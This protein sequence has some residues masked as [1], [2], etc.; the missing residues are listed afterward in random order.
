MSVLVCFHAHP[1][2][3]VFGTGG[4]MRLAA[5]AGHRVVLVVATDGA[6]GQVPDGLLRPG[7]SLARRRRDEVERSAA[8]LG[9]D[10]VVHLGYGDSGMAGEPTPAATNPF[11]LAALGEASSRLAAVLEE[12]RPDV[13]TVYDPNGGYG[14]PDHI[15]VHNVGVRAAQQVGMD[16]V[17][18]SSINRDHMRAIMEM[19]AQ[20]NPDLADME[21]P[22]LDSIGLPA[23]A[24]TTTVDVTAAMAAKRAAMLIH[25]TQI[26]DFGPMLGMDQ[27]QL[28]A[29]FGTEWFRRHGAEP[30]LTES[31]LPL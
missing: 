18:E 6:A 8:T 29:A 5:D 4:V 15:M 24:F 20:H 9:A 23:D 3:E 16:S 2:D 30:G 7:E 22:D 10:R 19:A 11:R 12:E 25:E 27:A 1:D 21:L 14:H 26:G 31:A 17:Y 13:L 28:A